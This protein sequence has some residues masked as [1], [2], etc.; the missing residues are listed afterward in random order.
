MECPECGSEYKNKTGLRI[1]YSKTHGDVEDLWTD[2]KCANCS[3]EMKMPDHRIRAASKFFCSGVCESE[4]KSEN[5]T[6]EN[7]PCWRGGRNSVEFECNYCGE[8]DTARQKRI[9]NQENIFCSI[10]CR[11]KWHKEAK[12]SRG[13]NNSQWK[14]GISQK[15][16]QHSGYNW[17]EQ[18]EKAIQ[19]DNGKCQECGLT[20]K[21]Q[22]EKYDTGFNVHHIKDFLE[23]DSVKEANKL[24]N[25]KT[26]CSKCHRLEHCD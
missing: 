6:G 18:R 22:H 20:R 4:H 8:T 11:S 5:L 10:E 14:G 26:L 1:H 3:K 19:R 7:N 12:I 24:D 15:S 17:S 23:F 16:R 21:H 9:D 13:E 2:V 25:L